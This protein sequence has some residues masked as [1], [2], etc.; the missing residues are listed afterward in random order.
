M[1]DES[2]LVVKKDHGLSHNQAAI[3]KKYIEEILGKS[4][5][6]QSNSPY[7]MPVL[8]VRKLERGLCIYIDYHAFNALTIKNRNTSPLIQKTFANLM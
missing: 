2:R 7:A 1:I 8:I 5:I 3:V 6:C 4:F